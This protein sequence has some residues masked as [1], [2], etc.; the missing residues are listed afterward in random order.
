M[1]RHL[2]LKEDEVAV[3]KEAVEK[4]CSY[5]LAEEWH[6]DLRIR[7]QRKEEYKKLSRLRSRL[8][9]WREDNAADEKSS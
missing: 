4:A 7:K 9:T 6:H 1:T 5:A 3:L 8:T 2:H